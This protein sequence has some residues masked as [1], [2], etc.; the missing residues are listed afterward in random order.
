MVGL[1]VSVLPEVANDEQRHM[2]APRYAL[3]EVDTIE[4]RR[5]VEPDIAFFG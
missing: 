5:C 2:V 3:V 4:L 1:R